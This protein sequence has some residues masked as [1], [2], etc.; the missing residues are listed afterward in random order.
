MM[1][2]MRFMKLE[3]QR[4][5]LRSKQ[6]QKYAHQVLSLQ[7]RSESAGI[8]SYKA[9]KWNENSEEQPTSSTSV[10][11]K[12]RDSCYAYDGPQA[13]D[14]TNPDGFPINEV[15]VIRVTSRSSPLPSF[16][17]YFNSERDRS[18][19]LV[20]GGSYED[21]NVLGNPIT[22]SSTMFSSLDQ[23]AFPVSTEGSDS[24]SNEQRAKTENTKLMSCAIDCEQIQ[25]TLHDSDIS[26]YADNWN[27]NIAKCG[28]NY[29]LSKFSEGHFVDLIKLAKGEL[30]IDFLASIENKQLLKFNTAESVRTIPH[31]HIHPIPIYFVAYCKK[32]KEKNDSWNYAD[33]KQIIVY[34]PMHIKKVVQYEICNNQRSQLTKRLINEAVDHKSCSTNV[35]QG[36][37]DCKLNESTQSPFPDPIRNSEEFIM[38]PPPQ[39]TT[40]HCRI[41]RDKGGVDR[42]IYPSYYLHLEREDLKFFL[43]AARRRKRSKTSNYVI[44]YDATDL[45]RDAVSLAGKLRS[46]F[47]GTQFTVYGCKF[48]SS[49]NE[50]LNPENNVHDLICLQQNENAKIARAGCSCI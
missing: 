34:P 23:S 7:K 16:N 11:D 30:M 21:I 17:Q 37:K 36:Y 2:D 22:R 50:S 4:E 9:N 20:N 8:N 29:S 48:K 10:K 24:E 35:S 28:D 1:E 39:G 14:A 12:K 5:L 6:K 40:I 15:Q 33:H 43:L 3:K 31:I 13:Y 18:V 49:D 47:L 41:T 27:R 46:N 19:S 44:S 45:S 38:K 25:G 42:G 32:H 26:L